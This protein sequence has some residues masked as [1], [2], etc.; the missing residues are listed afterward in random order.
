MAGWADSGRAVCDFVRVHQGALWVCDQETF[1]DKVFLFF[2]M[3]EAK[4]EAVSL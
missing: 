3:E 2:D 4:K 1:D